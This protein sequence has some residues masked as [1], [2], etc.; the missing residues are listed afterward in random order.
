MRTIKGN[1]TWWMRIWAIGDKI[2]I[3]NGCSFKRDLGR[4]EEKQKTGLSQPTV[5]WR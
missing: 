3:E 1:G 5:A 2:E 4:I